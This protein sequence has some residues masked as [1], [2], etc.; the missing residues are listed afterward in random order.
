MSTW[1]AWLAAK[2]TGASR[3]TSCSSP[4]SWGRPG[5]GPAAGSRCRA[6]WPGPGGPGSDGT[7]RCRSRRR[8]RARAP[9]GGPTRARWGRRAGTGCAR[10]GPAARRARSQPTGRPPPRL[11]AAPGVAAGRA[12]RGAQRRDV[13]GPASLGPGRSDRAHWTSAIRIGGAWRWVRVGEVPD[14]V[15]GHLQRVGQGGGGPEAE[16]VHGRRVAADDDHG[17]EVLAGRAR[18]S[19]TCRTGGRRGRRGRSGRGGRT[20]GRWRSDSS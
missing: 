7:R 15:A 1:L 14:D 5:P 10:P 3:S 9:A 8:A 19:T 2:M 12:R 20:T 17:A 11:V 13:R 4:R 18:T 16:P 6:P